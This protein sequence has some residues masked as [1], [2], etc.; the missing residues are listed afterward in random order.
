M[1]A[2]FSTITGN[3][4]HD[5]HTRMLFA[6][7]EQAGIK[8][9]GAVD[10]EISRNHIYHTTRGIWLDWMA[11]GTRIT[12]N[13]LH[14]NAADKINWRQH[15]EDLR[16]GGEQDLFVEVN[17]G[18][19]LVDNNIFLSA[20]SVNNRSEGGAYVHN[21]FAGAF[22]VVPDDARQTPF[23][24]PH[25]TEIAGLHHHQSGDDRYYNN[26]FVPP[27]DLS[28]YNEAKLPVW[29]EGNVFLGGAKPS[30]QEPHPLVKPDFNPLIKLSE[31]PD[32]FYLHLVLPG[33]RSMKANRKLVTT[34]RLGKAQIPNLPFEN[35]DGTPLK[36]D[37]D[38]FGSKRNSK[39]PF[40]GPFEVVEKSDA[41][42]VWPR[43]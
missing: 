13:F 34:D 28:G 37:A 10:V 25:A 33:A 8:F 12:G 22:R 7:A 1:G 30:T 29:M 32:G 23:L 17:H 15:W 26:L 20:Y 3:T 41:I 16:A 9:H 40:P 6:G 31:K 19:F 4:I 35:P 14:D 42:K 24:Q 18:P 36:V 27:S 38:Y 39:N 43:N 11:Q 5:I 2:A 21:L